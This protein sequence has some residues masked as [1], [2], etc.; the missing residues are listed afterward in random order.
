MIKIGHTNHYE[1]KMWSNKVEYSTA[2][3]VCCTTRSVKVPFCM[4][5]FSISKISNHRFHFDNDKGKSV[6]GYDMVIGR[7]LMVHLGITADFKHQFS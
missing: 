1:P 6:I 5:E 3:G 4:P 7:D 2:T